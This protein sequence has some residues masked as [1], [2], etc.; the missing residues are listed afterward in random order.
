[1]LIRASICAVTDNPGEVDL[2]ESWLDQNK[3]RL[4]FVS[5]MNGCGCCVFLWDI[6]G[7]SEVVD[8]LPT[9]LASSSE[10]TR[11]DAG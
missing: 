4:T 3:A 7:P 11:A 2:A 8:T 1:M 10:W 9:Q 5:D 6:E